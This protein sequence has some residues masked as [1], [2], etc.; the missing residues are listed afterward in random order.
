MC[1]GEMLMANSAREGVDSWRRR[2]RRSRWTD[3]FVYASRGEWYE[4]VATVAMVISYVFAQLKVN[5]GFSSGDEVV[6]IETLEGGVGVRAKVAA[7]WSLHAWALVLEWAVL[8][9]G[10]C[11]SG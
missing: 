5:C 6:A 8:A 3:C 7:R 4:A 11:V 1:D 9:R 2:R 10:V